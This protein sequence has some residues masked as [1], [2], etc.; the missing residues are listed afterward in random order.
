MLFEDYKEK[1]YKIIVEDYVF[2]VK[3]LKTYMLLNIYTA[4]KKQDDKDNLDNII[5]ITEQYIPELLLKENKKTL[6][7]EEMLFLI[8]EADSIRNKI[9]LEIYNIYLKEKNEL[10]NTKN[11]IE[12]E[13]GIV[14]E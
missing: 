1:T 11:K 13:R 9:A 3:E 6:E 10:E 2:Y 4:L 14:N 7:R 12:E 8:E 5:R